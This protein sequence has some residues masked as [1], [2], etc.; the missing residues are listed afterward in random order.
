MRR[1]SY[2]FTNHPFETG[3]GP[4]FTCLFRIQSVRG[5]SRGPGSG[6]GVSPRLVTFSLVLHIIS[7]LPGPH[8]PVGSAASP[9]DYDP[10]PITVPAIRCSH[11]CSPSPTM[12]RQSCADFPYEFGSISLHHS[13]APFPPTHATP[14]F[15]PLPRHGTSPPQWHDS[16]FPR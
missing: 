12:P 3:S 13:P 7:S 11:L 5:I 4:A 1:N 6:A 14:S 16:P 8:S 9:S 2:F 15:P 10:S